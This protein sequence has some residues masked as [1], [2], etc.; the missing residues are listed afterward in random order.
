MKRLWLVAIAALFTFGTFFTSC[1]PDETGGGTT[2]T[3]NFAPTLTMLA[4][5]PTSGTASVISSDVTFTLESAETNFYVAIE[6][7]DATPPLKTLDVLYNG[8]AAGDRLASI[9]AAD[10]A[11]ITVNNP[12]LLVSPYDQGFKFLVKLKTGT[13]FGENVYKFILTDNGGLTSEVSLTVTT[14]QEDQGTPITLTQENGLIFNA[15]GPNN[16]AFDLETFS[17]VSS[18]SDISE[19]QDNG[20]DIALPAA[21]NWKRTISPENGAT[22][23]KVNTTAMGENYDFYSVATKEEIL[24]AWDNGTAVTATTEAINVGDEFVVRSSSGTYFLIRFTAV[25]E[26]LSDNLDYYTLDM[27]Y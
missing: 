2:T 19:L 15:A 1:T 26:T 22:M 24:T 9:T 5:D 12:L 27:R 8:A 6:G 25:T 17:N 18:S 14:I 23:V 7:A 11:D 21:S 10:G 13:D 3:D 20:I 16:G 4:D